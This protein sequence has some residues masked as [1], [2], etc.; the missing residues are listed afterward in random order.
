MGV[1]TGTKLPAF[2]RAPHW[3]SLLSIFMVL[4]TLPTDSFLGIF[5]NNSLLR[6]ACA[7]L[8]GAREIAGFLRC[9]ALG[10]QCVDRGIAYPPDARR[11][12]QHIE[13]GIE[14]RQ[15]RQRALHVP[16]QE[17]TSVHRGV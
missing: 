16:R 1:V 12:P 17:L 6:E 4:L 13:Y 7:N 9:V 3:T 8:I 10:H 15:K 11:R 14:A 2:F 5:E